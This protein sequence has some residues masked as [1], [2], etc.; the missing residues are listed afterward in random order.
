VVEL[1]KQVLR[2]DKER[3]VLHKELIKL[4]TEKVALEIK[5]LRR[6]LMLEKE[7]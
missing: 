7:M 5:K 1:Q 4:K 6:E 3:I 2:E